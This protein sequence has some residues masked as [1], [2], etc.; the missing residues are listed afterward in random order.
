MKEQ[1]VTFELA[2][3]MKEKGFNEPCFGYYYVSDKKEVGLELYIDV[4]NQDIYFVQA[5]LWQQSFE[6]LKRKF[7]LYMEIGID[8][9]TYPKYSFKIVRFIGNPEDLSE[10]EWGW[11]DVYYSEYLY[12]DI[13][14]C[15]EKIIS[16]CLDVI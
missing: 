7:G 1:M 12:R 11:E 2:L 10:K 14:E 15:N 16:I 8:Q 9:T 4:R 6:W 3:K 13:K 5:P